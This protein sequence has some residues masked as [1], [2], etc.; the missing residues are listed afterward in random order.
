VLFSDAAYYTVKI[1][2][3]PAVW[4]T[5]LIGS[6][7]QKDQLEL[8][9]LGPMDDLLHIAEIE[10]PLH[11]LDPVPADRSKYGVDMHRRQPGPHSTHVRWRRRGR[12]VKLGSSQDEGCPVNDEMMSLT[13]PDGLDVR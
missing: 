1:A 3:R 10:L 13:V 6:E 5:V 7:P 2:R 11:R 9:L 4:L 12:V 8:M